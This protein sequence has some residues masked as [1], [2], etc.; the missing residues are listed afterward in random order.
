MD[1]FSAAI[2]AIFA[3]PN[4]AADA[5]WLEGGA[6]PGVPVRVVLRSPDEITEFGPARIQQPTTSIDVRIADVTKPTTS[7]RVSI[8][9]EFFTIQGAPRRDLRRLI[10]TCDLRPV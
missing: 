8:G 7:D 2:D 10:W 9:G 3:D 6:W 4:M 1:A 5:L